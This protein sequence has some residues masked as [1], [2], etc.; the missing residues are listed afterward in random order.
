MEFNGLS[1]EL[2]GSPK[3]KNFYMNGGKKGSVIT[4]A[5]DLI[6]LEG[7][8]LITEERYK[9]EHGI[10]S[11]EEYLREIQEVKDYNTD[12]LTPNKELENI[13]LNGNAII[14]RL[15]K[16]LPF[17]LESGIF[18]NNQLIT[19]YQTKGGK[20]ETMP[21]PLQFIHRGVINSISVQCSE[22]FKSTFK[23]GDV[24][25]LKMGLN[26]MAQRTFLN[27][28]EY[29]DNKF[30]NYFIFNENMIEKGVVNYTNEYI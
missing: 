11:D 27:P 15:F 20:F 29:Y 28:L 10:K 12:L 25:D 14:I 22:P 21:N 8:K 18:H 13:K 23:V 4:P 24:V 16:H 17:T 19:P 7:K 30:D 1:N 5:T 9:K 26:L 3:G 6:T 2:E